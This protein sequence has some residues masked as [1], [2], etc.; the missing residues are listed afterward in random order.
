MRFRCDNT[1]GGKQCLLSVEH[2]GKVPCRFI[3]KP[4][5]PQAKPLTARQ[6]FNKARKALRE[7]QLREMKFS[8]PLIPPSVNHYKIP[9]ANGRGFY[10]TPEAKAFK[11]AVASLTR[12]SVKA[13][14][15]EVKIMLY[16]G[17]NQKGDAD[18]FNKVTLD[19]L[20]EARII[21]TDAR[22]K[23]QA[24]PLRDWDNPRTEIEIKEWAR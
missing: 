10:V 11:A 8:I 19:A 20:V 21:T 17:K 22:V 18:N 7:P 5:A 16:L 6:A 1:E 2:I 12:G 13:D 3:P 4:P 24:I 14:W 23:V 9:K 15:Y